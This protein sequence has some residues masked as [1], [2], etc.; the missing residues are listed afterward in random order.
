MQKFV[1]AVAVGLAA[2]LFGCGGG[3]RASH[4]STVTVT[5]TT[6]SVGRSISKADYI[7]QADE[8][9]HSFH[10]QARELQRE[11]NQVQDFADLEK[12]AQKGERVLHD[13]STKLSA[14]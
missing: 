13:A 6:S 10:A 3:S 5:T 9:C 1:V 2:G 11:G 12:L 14:L 8:I 4:S 7:A